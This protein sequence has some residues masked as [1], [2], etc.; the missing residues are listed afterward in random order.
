[1]TIERNHLKTL[2]YLLEHREGKLPFD[3]N[4]TNIEGNTPLHVA[5]ETGQY[6]IVSYLLSYPPED[7]ERDP[8]NNEGLTPL[9]LAVGANHRDVVKRMLVKGVNRHIMNRQEERAIDLARGA[10][11]ID[12]VKIL[13]DDFSNWDKVKIACNVKIIYDVE[14]PT[15]SYCIAF[16][17]LFHLLFLPSQVF[18]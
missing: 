6:T 13:N 10:G 9:M 4:T 5:A 3:P 1:M 7:V 2:A 11:K 12:L 16:L 8:V 14:K 18:S 17:V 15:K